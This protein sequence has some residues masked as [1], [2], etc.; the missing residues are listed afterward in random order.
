VISNLIQKEKESDKVKIHCLVKNIKILKKEF[1]R[2]YM[3]H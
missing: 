1:H 2:S 3:L